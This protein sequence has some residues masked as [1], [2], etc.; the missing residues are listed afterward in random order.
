M[1]AGLLAF[2]SRQFALTIKHACVKSKHDVCIRYVEVWE[3]KLYFYPSA[4]GF[5][6]KKTD[7]SFSASHYFSFLSKRSG[8]RMPAQRSALHSL[9][10]ETQSTAAISS[11]T[12]AVLP[13]TW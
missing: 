12:I 13:G 6:K 3:L 5:R 7:L 11:R 8:R 9:H 4:G 1:A 10:I 2:S